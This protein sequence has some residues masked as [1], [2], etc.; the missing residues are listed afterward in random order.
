MFSN[1]HRRL[2]AFW[3]ARDTG[4]CASAQASTV[5]SCPRRGTGLPFPPPLQ[6]PAAAQA[7]EQVAALEEW[8]GL[9]RS[10]DQ[11]DAAAQAAQAS[12]ASVRG[13]QRAGQ[14]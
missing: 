14:A 11:T 7:A 10:R 5:L 4:A 9:L 1:A 2:R 12:V 6:N 3:R 8:V 13:R